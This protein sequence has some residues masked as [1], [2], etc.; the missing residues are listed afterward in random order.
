MADLELKQRDS[1]YDEKHADSVEKVSVDDSL[2][3]GGSVDDTEMVKEVEALE[4]RIEHD[5]ATEDEYRVGEAYEVAIKVCTAH[6]G[7]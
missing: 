5:E 2:D 7:L 6:P 1:A 3:K 4:D